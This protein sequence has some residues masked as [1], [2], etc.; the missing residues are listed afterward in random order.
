MRI[1]FLLFVFLLS[2]S[3]FAE[4][5]KVVQVKGD[6]FKI[7]LKGKKVALKKQDVILQEDTIVTGKDSLLIIKIKKHS[8]HKIEENTKIKIISLP[9]NF[10]KSKEVEK[11]ASF[12]L[13]VGTFFSKILKKTEVPN[14][15][16]KTKGST[17]GIRGTT[18]MASV[19]KKAKDVWL[20]VKN[21][22]VEI[23]NNQSG[24]HDIVTKGETLVVEKDRKFTRQRKYDWV[25]KV[26]WDVS[27]ITGQKK[28]FAKLRS[29]AYKKFKAK[30]APWVRD[31]IRFAKKRKKWSQQEK[32][33]KA[34]VKRL[35]PNKLRLKRNSEVLKIKN[36]F[37][38][39]NLIQR[40]NGRPLKRNEFLKRKIKDSNSKKMIDQVR[41]RRLDLKRKQQLDLRRKKELE[42]RKP[43]VPSY[44]DYPSP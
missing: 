43:T 10:E 5:I 31:E 33:W 12:Y 16:V 15:K 32:S 39:V 20:S 18:F 34:K 2:F 13:K 6:A 35:T 7:S 26:N 44:P 38:K 37:N 23:K 41:K 22:E 9:Y 24:Q 28:P 19:D 1:V 4:D 29:L 17:M 27:K 3:S 36:K 8:I 11:A 25:R 30:K 21:G 42:L 14:M 40:K